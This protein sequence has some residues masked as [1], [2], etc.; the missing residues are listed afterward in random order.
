MLE[1]VWLNWKALD[2]QMDEALAL[3]EKLGLKG[4]KV[5]FMDRDDQEMVD[6]Y[7]RL[8]KKAADHHLMVDLH[9]AYHPTGLIRTYPHFLTQEGVLGAEY[10]KW[11]KRVTATH[12]V[13]LPFTRMLLGPMDYTPGGMRSVAPAEFQVRYLQ[14][15]VQTTRGQG[16]AMYVVFDSPFACV[17]DSPEAYDGQDGVDFLRAVPTSWDETRFLAGDIGQYVVV[18]RR[19]GKDWYVGA[20]TNEQGRSVQ[21]PL[22]FLGGGNFDARVWGDAAAPTSLTV[23][24]RKVSAGDT[25]T[26]A[27]APS[28]GGAVRLQPARGR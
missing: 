19:K 9:G 6:Y 17:S 7:H 10:N 5:D 15:F 26:L 12:N 11:S 25:L 21:V 2:A 27:L 1:R 22:S 8:L 14:P 3:Y 23:S 18:A 16:L 4:I 28:G 13:T 20:M 24:D